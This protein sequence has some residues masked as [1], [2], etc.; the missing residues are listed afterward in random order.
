M[1]LGARNSSR[2]SDYYTADLRAGWD[3]P[4]AH[5]DLSTWVSLT[6]KTGRHN[7]CCVQF[8]A[9]QSGGGVA[10]TQQNSWFPRVLNLGFTW[11]VSTRP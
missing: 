8:L 6:N 2:W 5:S 11:R 1:T 3:V 9:P 7:A 10:V 4:L